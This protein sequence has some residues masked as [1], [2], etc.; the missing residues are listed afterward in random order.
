MAKIGDRV[1][2][3]LSATDT[4]V[5]FLGWGVYEGDFVP[6]EEAMGLASVIRNAGRKNP[7]IKLENGKYVFGCECWWGTEKQV[8]ERLLAGKE[9]VHVDIDDVRNKQREARNG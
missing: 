6:S 8:R 5:N 3:V 2:A 9:V 4:T 7:R 1:G